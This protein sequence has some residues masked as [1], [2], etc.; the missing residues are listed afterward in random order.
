MS[1]TSLFLPLGLFLVMAFM[2][3]RGFALNDPHELPSALLNQPLPAFEKTRLADGAPVTR[4]ALLGEPFLLNVWATWCPTCKA[5]HAELNRIAATYGVPLVGVNYKDNGPAARAW[6]AR[7]GDPY[8]LSLVDDDGSLGI[9]L[10][11]Y[12]APE[13]FVVDA[14]GVIR[15]K[16]VGAVDRR[17]WEEEIRPLLT[18]LGLPLETPKA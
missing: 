3:W 18:R 17:V 5:E 6:L 1:R 15:Y 2:L 8:R 9:E 11:V 4:D 10:G 13:T 7:Y 14:E 12:G 16:R